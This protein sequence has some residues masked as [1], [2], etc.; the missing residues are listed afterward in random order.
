[1]SDA[2]RIS[3]SYRGGELLSRAFAGDCIFIGRE[4]DCELRLNH[5]DV[6][7]HHAC[8]TRRGP[9]SYLMRD[10][11]SSNGTFVQEEAVSFVPIREGGHARIAEFDLTFHL[12]EVPWGERD[13]PE[14]SVSRIWE[15]DT[16]K[17]R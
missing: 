17:V 7:R 4:A 1:M 10:L 6:S 15:Q 13:E 8:I 9:N 12:V 16:I 11:A 14:T 2:L 3:V 5:P